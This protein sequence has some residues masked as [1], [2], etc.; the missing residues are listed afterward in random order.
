M[1]AT[2]KINPEDAEMNEIVL[3][4]SVGE[5]WFG[6]ASFTAAD[7][8]KSLAEMSGP[9]TVRLNSGGGVASEGQAIY[10]ALLDYPD[11]VTVHIDGA[12]AS[13]ASLIAMAGDKIVMRDGAWMLIHDPAQPWAMNRGTEDDHRKTADEL[14]VIATGYA[15]V[16]ARRAGIDLAAAREIM[17]AETLYD[18][19]AAVAAGFATETDEAMAATAATFDYRIYANAPEAARKASESLGR[20]A[21]A[22]E[23]VLAMFAG[24]PRTTEKEATMADKPAVPADAPVA[25]PV[26]MTATPPAPVQPAQPDMA[27]ERARSRRIAEMF[28]DAGLDMTVAASLIS[29]G[30]TIEMAVDKSLELRRAKAG[31]HDRNLPPAPTARIGR[32]ERD[33]MRA[34]M[35]SAITAQLARTAPESDAAR[36]W[37]QKSIVEMA[38]EATDYRG[39]LRTADDRNEA[40]RMA[41]HSTSDFPIILE[42]ALN[43]RL[44]DSYAKAVP[45]YMA[46][47]ER[48]DFNDFRPHPIS[49]V[50][51]FPGLL[52]VAET[53]EIRFGTVGEKKETVTL[54][55]YGVGLGI[56]RQ[57]L[58]NDDLSAI[59]RVLRTRGESVAA[60]EDATFWSMFLSGSNADG[61]T[62]TETG[63][64][65]FN[66]TD[67]TKAGSNAAITITSLAAGRAAMRKQRG[68]QSAAAKGDGQMLNLQPTI[69]L[70]GPDKETEAQ[71]LVTPIQP[72]QASNVNPFQASLR[73]ITT[74]YITGNSWYLMAEPS[75]LASFMYGFLNGQAGPRLRMD[76]PFGVQGVRYTL[77]RD[78][79]CGAIDFRSVYR[80]VGA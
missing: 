47:A 23:A 19:Q 43:K 8:R 20:K 27:A 63:R 76:E 52:P 58:I 31:T 48:I 5:S 25:D 6:E 21:P 55:A 71:Q 53:G 38:A 66:T 64:Q 44:A 42:N 68:I 22:R 28:A 72:S 49:N 30:A 79:G 62:L 9:I 29:E 13:A 14:S 39:P 17:K 36:G 11:E 37:M 54:V 56:S 1:P 67:G 41:M 26:V 45:T 10:T 35:Q 80:N 33:T 57:M 65:V 32:D 40:I 46:V 73:I 70:V 50:G 3:Y 7:V 2:V 78:F 74:P 15:R 51:D 61:P 69:L 4:G 34:G 60:W 59:D 77:E 75:R 24:A 16:Y 12:A 18:A